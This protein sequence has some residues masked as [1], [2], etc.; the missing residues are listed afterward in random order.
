MESVE[1]IKVYFNDWIRRQK[2]NSEMAMK[3]LNRIIEILLEKNRG[4]DEKD[5]ML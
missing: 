2:L 1:F 5:E 3:I 4:E